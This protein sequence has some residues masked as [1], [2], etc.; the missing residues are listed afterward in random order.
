[1]S[2]RQ[3]AIVIV[4]FPLRHFHIP[5]SFQ[6]KIHA[7]D[8]RF[9]QLFSFALSDTGMTSDIYKQAVLDALLLKTGENTDDRSVLTVGSGRIC[10]FWYLTENTD[11]L[12][13]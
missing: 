2:N 1:M 8:S 7:K 9:K 13:L 12:E 11:E 5:D 6:F 4:F 10:V 3:E